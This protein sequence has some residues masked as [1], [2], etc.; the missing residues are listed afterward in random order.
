M[1]AEV[2]G[3]VTQSCACVVGLKVRAAAAASL[4]ANR[5]VEIA[6]V[7]GALKPAGTLLA[8]TV[9]VI[10]GW[11]VPCSATAAAAP[12]VEYPTTVAVP[13]AHCE[14]DCPDVELLPHV[15]LPVGPG[16]WYRT[17][18]VVVVPVVVLVRVTVS[19]IWIPAETVPD[20][21]APATVDWHE[22][23]VPEKLYPNG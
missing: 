15:P 5:V 20:A 18:P 17:V 10:A 13:S 2:T 22:V 11:T 7:A 9:K 1:L 4:A 23:N 12:L 3:V 14:T 8:T 19:G 21:G 6:K 16:S